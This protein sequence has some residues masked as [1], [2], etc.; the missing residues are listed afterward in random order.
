MTIFDLLILATLAL[1]VALG[2]WRGLL[3]EAVLMLSWILSGVLA[4]FYAAPASRLFDGLIADAAL[5]QLLAFVLIFVL[6]FVL[7]LVASWF[8][9]KSVPRWRGFRLANTALGGVIGAARGAVLVIAVFLVAGLTS[10][11]QRDWWRDSACTPVFERA[12][13]Y[14][15][16]YIPHDIARHIRYS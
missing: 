14:V 8:L 2:A 11:P 7:G 1:F 6:V 16:G 4:W 15:A 12:A 13:I 3:R 9:H 5:R 10:F